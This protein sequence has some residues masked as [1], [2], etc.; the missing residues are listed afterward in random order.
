MG[1]IM[2]LHW[3]NLNW[4]WLA[5]LVISLDAATKWLASRLLPYGEPVE[6]TGFFNLTLLHNH[7]AAFSFLA[8]QDGWQRWGFSALAFGVS[9]GLLFWLLRLS[10][11][12]EAR[13]Q[14]LNGLLKIGIVLIIGGALGNLID[15][16]SLGYV[17]DFLDFHAR[18]YHWPAF[19]VA[20]SAITVGVGLLL[21]AEVLF[22]PSAKKPA[23]PSSEPPQ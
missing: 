3:R 1:I 12:S 13:A 14:R 9:L 16:L 2:S 7:G 17:V 22:A 18:G 10:P 5:A 6:L 19:N 11:A 21:L 23:T 8:S 20:D 4:L 15:R